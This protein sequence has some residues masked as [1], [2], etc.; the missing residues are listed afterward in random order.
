[1]PYRGA[2][3]HQIEGQWFNESGSL[4][5][6]NQGRVAAR[7]TVDPG[8]GYPFGAGHDDIPQL[9]AIDPNGDNPNLTF[10]KD[11]PAA[12]LG[13]ADHNKPGN[14]LNGFMTGDLRGLSRW[15]GSEGDWAGNRDDCRVSIGDW[16][17][18]REER[19]QQNGMAYFQHELNDYVKVRGE[20]VA[21]SL[22]YNTRDLPGSLDE[23]DGR[24]LYGNNV[25]IV[26]GSNPG[27]PFRAFAD[28]T[29]FGGWNPAWNT[30]N[31]LD[32]WDANGNGRYDY[33][34]EPGE[35][36]VFAQDANGDG[37]PDRDVD[38]DGMADPDAQRRP[39]FRVLLPAIYADA[40]GDGQLDS[41]ADA[42]GDGVPD[43]FDPDAGV[44]LFEDVKLMEMTISP[45]QPYGNTI[46]W[47]NDDMTYSRRRQIDNLRIR[48]GT[49]I[50]IPDTEWIVDLDW[51]WATS[52]R[53]ED[54]AEPVWPWAVASMRCQGGQ[55]AD[56]CWNPF[57]TAWLDSD[58]DGQ[59]LPAWRDPDHPAANT[60]LEHR[61]AGVLLRH[62]Q[63]NLGMYI[64]D[65]TISNN[66]LFNL[67]YNDAPVGFAAGVHWRIG[68]RGIPPEPAGRFRPRL[69]AHRLPVHGRR[70]ASRLHGTAAAADFAS[71][72][73]RH[74]GADGGALRPVRGPWHHHLRRRHRPVRHHHPEV[75]GALRARRLACLPW[76]P[77]P[78]VRVA[79]H[80]PAVPDHAEPQRLR[81]G[82]RLR[83]RLHAGA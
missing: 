64:V 30:V 33:L 31:T 6:D 12:G 44:R 24:S 48:L 41:F 9:S 80:V 72:V 55:F 68:E 15:E 5:G 49:E 28:G 47:L 23:W 42:D 69:G 56:Q 27:N 36:L 66:S 63:R 18:I 79:G 2:N 38:G 17:D 21:S 77:D 16:Q 10:D 51:I 78:R 14:F 32:Y 13:Y 29:G 39:E 3:W 35:F 11:R 53:E 60:E 8:C 37:I 58:E 26:V 45:K 67:W 62:D 1:M 74:G 52:K 75:G 25:P 54:Y 82:A 43:R 20:I 81:H 46:D 83:L 19:D 71:Q 73:G 7:R 59:I 65:A 70:D 50:S 34:Q 22:D 40:D 61:N 76:Q 4:T 57:S